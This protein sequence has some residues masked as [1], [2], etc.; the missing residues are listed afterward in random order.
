MKR[1]IS[2]LLVVACAFSFALT[3]CE[4]AR[5]DM[6]EAAIIAYLEAIRAGDYSA[7][8]DMLSARTRNE[9]DEV[10]AN[11]IGLQEF[12][13]KYTNIFDALEITSLSYSD[14][15]CEGGDILCAGTY[16]AVYV[17]A[18]T[19]NLE[20]EF[21]I[22]ARREG[23]AWRIAWSPALI[24][25]EMEWGDTVRVAKLSAKRGEILADG[26]V[27]AA[28]VGAVSVYATVSKIEDEALFVSQVSALLS[29][30]PEAVEKALTKAYDDV[31]I[32]K[33]FYSDELSDSVKEQLLGI[34]GVGVDAGNYGLNRE[35]PEKSLLAHLI[36]YVG[37]VP[38]ASTEA[39][40]ETLAALNEGRSEAD[41]LY[42][43]DSIIGRLGLEKQYEQ[44]L[45]GTDGEMAYILTAEGTNRQT[46]YRRAA[47]NGYDLDLTIDIELQR[48]AEEVMNLVLFGD[49]TAGSVIVLD[50]NTGAVQAMCSYPSYDLNSFTRGISKENYDALLNNPAK[51]LINRA[52]QGLYPPGSTIKAFTAAS[53]LDLGVL[54]Q[55][56][57]FNESQI[58]DDYW[59][60]TGYGTWIWSPIKRTHIDY[61]ISG[62]LNMRKAL[63][64][65]DNIYFANCALMTGWD[66]FMG[67]MERIGFTQAIPFDIGVATPQL[68]NEESEKTYKLLADSGYGQGEILVTPLQLA[69]MFSALANGGNIMEPYVVESVR[70]EEGIRSVEVSA[71]QSSVWK[72]GVISQ[73]AIDIITPMLKDVV[74][75]TINGTGQKLKVKGCTVAA[76]TG[77]AEIGNDKSREISWF[78]GYRVGVSQEDARLVLV[79]L[80]IPAESKYTSLKFDIARALLSMKTQ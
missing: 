44:M 20:N 23:G 53:V 41:G 29:M 17:S 13:D 43:A 9:T 78:V 7:A 60:P 12:I 45:R 25:P 42:T 56:Y 55:N 50:P 65:S 38:G 32:L 24:F 69:S 77:T 30:K 16:R 63:I 26:D 52:T 64:H 49:T 46:L 61:P 39:I 35:Y 57:A 76:K 47:Q 4:A 59:K 14:L 40:E 28:T 6:G 73:S 67:Y 62:Y 70:R 37:S 18:Y 3:G 48:R 66:A 22:T 5:K 58:D 31:A 10:K 33:Q 8:W 74:D 2:L 75:P 72:T 79:M 11:R 80:E 27:L 71:H 21:R 15:V 68:A 54:D 36:G 19:G 34:P 1:F 51:P